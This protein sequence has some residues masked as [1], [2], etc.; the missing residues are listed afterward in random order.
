MYVRTYVRKY[1]YIFLVRFSFLFAKLELMVPK[2]QRAAVQ[3]DQRGTKAVGR[4][5]CVFQ[6]HQPVAKGGSHGPLIPPWSGRE[7][8]F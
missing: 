4:A 1:V 2:Q 8:D 6:P 5:C 3:K 7:I